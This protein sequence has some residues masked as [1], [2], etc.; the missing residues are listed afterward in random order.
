MVSFLPPKLPGIPFPVVCSKDWVFWFSWGSVASVSIPF[1]PTNT[2]AHFGIF[3]NRSN[4]FRMVGLGI[5]CS[6]SFSVRFLPAPV[7]AYANNLIRLG[8]TAL[9]AQSVLLVSASSTFQA[10]FA[11]GVATSVRWG[12]FLSPPDVLRILSYLPFTLP[13]LESE[14]SSERKMLDA[15]VWHQTRPS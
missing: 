6:C 3:T 9:A 5:S 7:A 13:P 2:A 15:Q 11:L 10:P 4:G 8:P 12:F 1:R 14:I